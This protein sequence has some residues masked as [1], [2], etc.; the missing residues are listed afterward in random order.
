[1]SEQT[2]QRI[3]RFVSQGQLDAGAKIAQTKAVAGRVS[4]GKKL[5]AR[6]C[7][8]CHGAKGRAIN[9]SEDEKST[10]FLGTIA[11]DNPW[12]LLHKIR[13]G[14]PGA[15]MEDK[16]LRARDPDSAGSHMRGGM[17]G[18]M[19]AGR[20]MPAFRTKLSVAEQFDLLA[21]LQTLPSE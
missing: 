12:E 13:N 8:A 10:E 4:A 19:L 7:M 3:A 21:Y 6:Q 9:F 15:V 14:Q 20:A 11:A 18:H 1:M 16:Q 2:L 5:F 17:R